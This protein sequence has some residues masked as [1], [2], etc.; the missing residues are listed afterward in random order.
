MAADEADLWADICRGLYALDSLRT[1][2][3]QN[4]IK[5]N[6][7]HQKLTAHP[8]DALTSKN[9][10]KLLEIYK[11]AEHQAVLEK[12]KAHSLVEQLSQLLALREAAETSESR[13]LKRKPDDLKGKPTGPVV[14]KLKSHADA[15]TPNPTAYAGD[16]SPGDKVAVKPQGYDSWILAEL[17][18]WHPDKSRWE[19]EDVE[20][21]DDNEVKKRYFFHPKRFI[22]IPKDVSKKPEFLIGQ[23]VLAL[24]PTTSCFYS[25]T[26]MVPPSRNKDGTFA[27]TYVLKFEDDEGYERFVDPTMVLE[28]PKIPVIK[29]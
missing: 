11:E 18:Q 25:A 1:A 5:I 16:S 9:A 17:I 14:K 3:D 20:A 7:A 28:V 10:S 15:T 4:I 13:K 26:V 19:L 24:Y 6:K 12:K 23:Q 8:I 21:D 29:K 22:P 2:A 27:G